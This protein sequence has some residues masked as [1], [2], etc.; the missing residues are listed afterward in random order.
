MTLYFIL[1]S[2]T[3]VL[4]AMLP[5]HTRGAKNGNVLGS[6]S[7]LIFIAELVS[8]IIVF[9]VA[10]C[11][12]YGLI[13]LAIVML[14]APFIGGVLAGIFAERD[15]FVYFIMGTTFVC[16]LLLIPLYLSLFK[17]L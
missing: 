9:F 16:L 1:L 5:R 8:A 15:T 6:L 2:I 3:G 14:A 13:A 7:T 11:W 17:I 12:W 4:S 10:P